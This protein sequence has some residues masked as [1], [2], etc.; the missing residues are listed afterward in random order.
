[1]CQIPRR[2]YPPPPLPSL[3]SMLHTSCVFDDP[4]LALTE[5]NASCRWSVGSGLFLASFAAVMGPMNYV[6][7]LLSPPRL[8]FTTAYFGSIV[9]TLVFAIKVCRTCFLAT[10]GRLRA[11]HLPAAK[12]YSHPDRRLDPD[13]LLALVPRELLPDGLHRPSSGYDVWRKAGQRVDVRLRGLGQEL[14]ASLLKSHRS[15]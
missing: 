2:L 12:Y 14:P 10:E 15:R 1:M 5:A 8:P 9:L 11:N 4:S 13:R 6:Y 3:A 7:H